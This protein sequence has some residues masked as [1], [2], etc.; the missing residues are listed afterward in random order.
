VDGFKIGTAAASLEASYEF[1]FGKRKQMKRP[2]M[3][4]EEKKAILNEMASSSLRNEVRKII[5]SNGARLEQLASQGRSIF[6]LRRIEFEAAD[7]IISLV[8]EKS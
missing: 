8:K 3:T 2:S 1:Y 5:C 7:K 4:E 6:D